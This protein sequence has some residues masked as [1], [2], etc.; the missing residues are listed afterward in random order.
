MTSPA[1]DPIAEFLARGGTIKHCPAAICAA[2]EARL[3]AEDRAQ[4]AAHSA[5]QRGAGWGR[6]KF[7]LLGRRTRAAW[8]ST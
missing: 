2:T 3:S 4:L 6:A 5:G 8:I 7:F 1:P